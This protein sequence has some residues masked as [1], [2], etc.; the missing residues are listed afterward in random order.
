[1]SESAERGAG[2]RVFVTGATGYIGGRLVPRLLERGYAVRCLTRSARKLASRP[3]AEHPAL[4]VVE[5]SVED[6]AVLE[7]GLA[8]CAAAYYLVHSMMAAGDEYA[9]RDRLLAE[10]FGRAAAAARLPRI[11]YLGG[12]GETGDALSE[13]L[14]SR[15]EVEHAL[16]DGA[17]GRV[18]ITVLRAAMIIGSGSASFEIL[19]YLVERLPVMVTPRWVRTPCQP[20]AVSN[21]LHDLIAC[22]EVPET[23]GETLD[24]G[25]PEV[26][27]YR[28]LMDVMADA[29]GLRRR[30]VLPVPLLTPRLSSLWIHLV[31]PLSHRIARPLADG[32]RNPVVCRD[33]RAQ[34]LMPQRLLTVEEAIHAAVGVA[35][36]G[37]VETRW[38]DA[39]PIPGDPDWAGGTTFVDRRAVE[40][41]AAPDAVF[42]AV[43]RMGG[44]N[45]W[46][47]ADAL[48]RIRGFLDHLVGGPGL[49]RGRRDPETVGYGDALD[50]WR[51][52]A[53][54]REGET[55]R[56]ELRAE[57]KLPGEALLAFEITPSE[58]APGGS[59]LTQTAHFKPRGLAGLLY[60]AAV[61]PFHAFV[62]RGMLEGIRRQAL[63][64]ERESDGPGERA[65]GEASGGS[66]TDR[67]VS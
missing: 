39:G 66:A 15:R 30:L 4:E 36:S 46:Y 38:T 33:D 5:G 62:F 40:L 27:S 52:T 7:R 1:M 2:E 50:F 58:G 51:V 18:A 41:D 54:E 26:V 53:V 8:D 47:A 49:R 44:G 37:E 20:I 65:P 56:L 14:R 32:L 29:L 35:A 31:T 17:E 12:L 22:L 28:E 13:H 10:G 24:I 67:A 19:R 43:C 34:S 57:M 11:V 3:W 16:A 9:A 48:W 6:T 25:G 23:A 42:R 63:V 59:R 64:L 45:G 61:L 21:V 60:W 55:K